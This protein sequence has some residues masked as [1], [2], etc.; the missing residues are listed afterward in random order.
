MCNIVNYTRAIFNKFQHLILYGIIG[1]F[2]AGLDFAVYTLL[3]ELA[4]QEYIV[5]NGI[6]VFAGIVTSFCLNRKYNFKVEDHAQKR[7]LIFLTVGLCGL[8]LSDIILYV[9]IDMFTLHKIASKVVAIVLVV[10]FQFLAN[11]LITFK[12]SDCV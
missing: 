3:V 7:F 8:V 10:F 9:C 11:K 2:S 6:S 1:S 4:E 5:A 12:P